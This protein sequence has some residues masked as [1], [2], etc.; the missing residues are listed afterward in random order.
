MNWCP[1]FEEKRA[2]MRVGIFT[3]LLSQPPLGA[4]LAELK[5]LNVETLALGTGYPGDA[6]CTLDARR[7][8]SARR[9]PEGYR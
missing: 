1:M 5:S 2:I 9:V 7:G 8:H 6:H 4:V 3:P